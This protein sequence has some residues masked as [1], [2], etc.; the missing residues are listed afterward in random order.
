MQIKPEQLEAHLEKGLA[1]VYLLS[2]DEPLQMMEAADAVRAAARARGHTERLVFSAD[3]G[4]DWGRLREAAQS[5]SLFASRRILELR[6]PTGKPGAEGGRAL[7]AYAAQPPEDTV[8]LVQCPRLEAK[9]RKTAWCRALEGAGVMLQVW[10]LDRSATEA[11]MARRLRQRGLNPTPEALRLLSDRVEGNLLAAAQEMEKLLLLTGPGEL[12][13]PAVLA[14]VSDSARFGVF[15][16]VDAALAAD[17]PRAVRI[18]QGLRG[19]GTEPAVVLWALAREIRG[20][21]RMAERGQAG[22]PMGQLLGAVRPPRRQPLVRAALG[23]LPEPALARLLAGCAR[24]DRIIKG[25]ETGSPWD[26]LLDWTL[27]LAGAPVP[28]RAC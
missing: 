17:A 2:G 21:H 5:L 15:D 23:R 7:E 12:D 3:A 8:L 20:L 25:L 28:S 19:E 10:P 4:F 14:A 6:L 16:L 24:A 13:A 26:E 18:L 27:A 11:W 22:E 1:P 9:D